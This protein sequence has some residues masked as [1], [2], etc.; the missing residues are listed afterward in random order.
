MTPEDKYKTVLAEN[1]VKALKKRGFDACY[2]R[3][4]EAALGKALSLI[5]PESVV[6]W[7]GS[8]SIMQ[9]GLTKTLKNGNYKV[10]DRADA[11]DEDEKRLMYRRAFFSDWYLGSANAVS[12]DG[13][14]INI[15]GSGNRVAAM[16]YGPDNVLLIV[17]I[18]KI[19]SDYESAVKRAKNVASP[20]NVQRFDKNTPCKTLGVCK[21]CLCDDCI[22][23]YI[24]VIRRC[25]PKGRIKVIITG[26]SLG[27]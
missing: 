27:F 26:E 5:E 13:E 8:Q 4:K 2:C 14:I 16:M 12:A 15:D 18:N 6:T 9:I 24:T 11:K 1:T 21:D 7:G 19:A 17:G 20:I 3:D 25:K 10:T 23:S 22:C